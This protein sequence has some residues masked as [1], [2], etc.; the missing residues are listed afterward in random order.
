MKRRTFKRGIVYGILLV[1]IGQYVLDESP[2][3]DWLVYPLLTEE[4]RG[5]A[6]A[7][8]VAGAGLVG[9]CTPNL[10]AVRRVFKAAQLW[11]EQRA[12]FVLFTGGRPPDSTCAVG[13]IMAELAVRV[14][15]PANRVLVEATSRST[16][17]NA[18]YAGPVLQSLNARRVVLVTDSLHMLRASSVFGANGYAVERAPVPVY[19]THTGNLDMLWSG[20]RE[21]LALAYYQGRGWLQTSPAER[22]S[23]VRSEPAGKAPNLEKELMPQHSETPNRPLIILG[24]SYAAG[25]QPKEFAGRPVVNQGVSGQQSFEVAER[26]EKDVVALEPEAVVLWGFINDIFRA[27]RESIDSAL[28]KTRTSYTTM[29]DRARSKGIKVILATEVTITSQDGWQERLAAV[30]G[31]LLGKAS[32]QDVVNAHIARTNDW[33]RDTAQ[34]E[35]LLLLDLERVVAGTD[36]RRR[37]E[38]ALPDGS[39][40]SDAG[41]EAITRY[42]GP[43]LERHLRGSQ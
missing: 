32:S 27:P 37:R 21:Y 34:R 1:L 28:A 4:T 33:I 10:S 3:A 40:L 15:V 12:P 26:F 17:E 6:D 2:I 25:W 18:F 24:A 5:S 19:A 22:P 30:V 16:H 23:G 42:A 20:S 13:D 43:I 14:G 9:P 38:F 8:V 7:I 39:H 11:R 31:P 29:I 35:G 41:Y 36:G